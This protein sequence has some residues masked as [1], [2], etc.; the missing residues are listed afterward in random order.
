VLTLESDDP[1]EFVTKLNVADVIIVADPLRRAAIEAAPRLRFVQHQGVGYHGRVDLV[2]LRTRSI[3][4][5]ITPEGTTEGV[6]EHVVLLILAVAKHLPLLDR[7]LRAG[8]FLERE[9]RSV[10]FELLGKTV[11]FVGMGKIGQAA[12]R[13]LQPFGVTLLYHDVSPLS[14]EPEARLGLRRVG[15]N[16]LL[17]AS[18]IVSLNLP[19]TEKTRHLMDAAAFAHMKPGAILVNTARGSLVDEAALAD[20][21]RSGRLAGAGL[22]VYETEPLPASHALLALPNTVLTPHVACGTHDAFCTKMKAIFAN[23]QRLRAG[24]PLHNLVP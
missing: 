15:F 22:D 21:L 1:A 7:E 19:G 24:E 20:V 8:H 17:A 18:D 6:A 23:V 3:P 10:S 11:G 9:M 13:R 2:A 14:A 16:E 4:F 5:A 12:A